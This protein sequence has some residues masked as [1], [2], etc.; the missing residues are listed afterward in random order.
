M[1]LIHKNE[2]IVAAQATPQIDAEIAEKCHFWME[3]SR[4]FIHGG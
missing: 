3:T 1:V 2:E 4:L